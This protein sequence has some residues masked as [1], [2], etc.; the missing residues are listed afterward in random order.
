MVKLV[1]KE[2]LLNEISAYKTQLGCGERA[3][4]EFGEM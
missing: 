1:F 3:K 4:E 2:K